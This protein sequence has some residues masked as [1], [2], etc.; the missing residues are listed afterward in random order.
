M[1]ALRAYA[2]AKIA[3]DRL[4]QGSGL[5]RTI[6]GP[7]L[8]TLGAHRRYHGGTTGSRCGVGRWTYLTHQRGSYHRRHAG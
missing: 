7:G 6:L 1:R 3:A 4:L 8:L 2:I 5:E